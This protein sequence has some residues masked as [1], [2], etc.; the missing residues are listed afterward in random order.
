[1]LKQDCEKILNEKRNLIAEFSKELSNKDHQYIYS[2]HKFKADTT[3]IIS[4]MRDQFKTLRNKM[5]EIIWNKEK[6]MEGDRDRKASSLVILMEED[7]KKKNC[8]EGEFLRDRKKLLSEY[9][10]NIKNLMHKLQTAETQFAH[11]LTTNEDIKEA[12]CEKEA[13]KEETKFINKIIVMEKFFNILKEQIEDFT[14]E[15]KILLEMLEYRVEVREEKIKEN[16]EKKEQ[17]TKWRDRMK[18]K[19]SKSIETYKTVDDTLRSENISLKLD[20]IKTTESFDDLKKKFRHFETYDEER[21][22]KIYNMNF[23]ES[24]N[25]A[26]KV[27]LA[28]RTIKSQ[29]L[30]IEALNNDPLEGFTLK[31][32]QDAMQEE[33]EGLTKLKPTKQVKKLDSNFKNHFLSKIPFDRVK[34]VFSLIVQ[35]AEFLI[36]IK[37]LEQYDHLPLD[38]KLPHYIESIC[39]GLQIKNENELNQLLD[40][41]DKKSLNLESNHNEDEKEDSEAEEEKKFNKLNIDPDKVIEY[42]KEFYEERKKNSKNEMLGKVNSSAFDDEDNQDALKER[43]IFLSETVWNVK[44]GKIISE[45][46]HNVWKALYNGLSKYHDLLFERKKMILET[47][48]LY[49]KNK[50]LKKMLKVYLDKEENEALKVPP[51]QTIKVDKIK[52]ALSDLGTNPLSK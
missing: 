43:M 13:Y 3:K 41:F 4:L 39:K 1:M 47:S 20:F 19:I 49:E 31:E 45:K 40:L 46:T 38:D 42:L 48:E 24:K 8:I 25:I 11:T 22:M 7:D 36:D 32:L 50:E 51:Y 12:E 6:L 29:Q 23:I 21:F 26:I 35:E 52:Y 17:Y 16:K 9:N 30:G 33:E 34:E 37:V 18:V 14:Y 2:L 5:L 27:L 44:F 10:E 15:L 28:D